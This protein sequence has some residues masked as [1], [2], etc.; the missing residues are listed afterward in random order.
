MAPPKKKKMA[1]P[2]NLEEMNEAYTN[3]DHLVNADLAGAA[4]MSTMDNTPN[5][6][7]SNMGN[8]SNVRELSSEGSNMSNMSKKESKVAEKHTKVKI[9][10]F[11]R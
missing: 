5:L 2:M 4:S 11:A 8:M 10:S 1:G 7:M 6:L 9:C 3:V